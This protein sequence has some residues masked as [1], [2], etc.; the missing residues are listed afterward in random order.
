MVVSFVFV[1]GEKGH[2][3][4]D[5]VSHVVSIEAIWLTNPKYFPLFT[6]LVGLQL[7]LGV[8]SQSLFVHSN[9]HGQ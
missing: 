2:L 6:T 1:F 4:K 9:Q 3:K 5:W 7:I 8:T